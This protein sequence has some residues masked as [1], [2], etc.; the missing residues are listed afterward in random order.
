MRESGIFGATISS[1][2]TLTKDKFLSSIDQSSQVRNSSHVRVAAVQSLPS[3]KRDRND[4]SQAAAR[5]LLDDY[6]VDQLA[7]PPLSPP[8]WDDVDVET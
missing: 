7:V 6:R 4:E 2:R 5:K 1:A 3:I 8:L